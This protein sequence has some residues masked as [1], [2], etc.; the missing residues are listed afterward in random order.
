MA[1]MKIS[2]FN[3]PIY[4]IIIVASILLGMFYIYIY[5]K[6][7]NK[8]KPL[9]WLYFLLSIYMILVFG[10]LF[11]FLT[12][13]DVNFLKTGLTSYG[14]AF[15]LILATLIFE[16]IVPSDKELVKA[17]ILSLPFIYGISK[18]GCFLVGCCYGIPYD[19]I[20]SITYVDG[21]NIPVFP[22][23]LLETI[24]FLIIFIFLNR[25]KDSKN[26]VIISIITMSTFKFLLDFLRYEHYL[27][28]FTTNQFISLF[29]LLISLIYFI[30]HKFVFKKSKG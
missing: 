25:F 12:N 3:F 19:G 15:G 21:A 8:W 16:K 29:V 18:I 14:G 9:M 11:T 4:A 2:E 1:N 22:V 23:Q 24:I 7:E 17:S 28:G 20:L 27:K 6:K 5:L 13:P 10:K 26:I 30:G